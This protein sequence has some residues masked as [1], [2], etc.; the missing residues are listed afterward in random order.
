M[1]Q[2]LES[3]AL[4]YHL[5]SACGLVRK[6]GLVLLIRNRKRGWELPGGIIEQGETV[7]EGLRREIHEESGIFCEPERLTGVYQ[8]LILK[9]GYGPLEGMK[10]PPIVTFAFVCRYV[11]G[12]ASATEESADARWVTPEEAAGMVTHPLY[13]QRLSDMLKSDDSVVFSSYEHDN[14]NT[15]FKGSVQL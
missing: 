2:W 4:P 13:V 14:N 8:N 11:S 6:D 1:D 7:S 3:K 5:I 9:D 10:L 15:F 12:E